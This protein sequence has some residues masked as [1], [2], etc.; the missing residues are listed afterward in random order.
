MV[1][2][3]AAIEVATKFAVVSAAVIASPGTTFD[4]S[5]SCLGADKYFHNNCGRDLCSDSRADIQNDN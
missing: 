4:R 1:A 5:N 2:T 3:V